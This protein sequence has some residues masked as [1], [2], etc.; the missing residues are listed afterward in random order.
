MKAINY[1][2]IVSD[3]KEEQ[4]K[5]AGL[6]FTEK[7]DLDNRYIRA[8]VISC[9]SKVEGVSDGDVVYYD[10]HAGHGMT[11]GDTLYKIIRTQDVI[12]VE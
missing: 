6:I 12:L 2:L 5:I 11:H 7:T 10:R 1:Y 4:K 9:G 8:R 3:V